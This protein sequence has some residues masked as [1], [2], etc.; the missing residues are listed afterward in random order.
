V[1][2]VDPSGKV[3]QFTD[4]MNKFLDDL[5]GQVD[6]FSTLESRANYFLTSAI[7]VPSNIET[8]L[9]GWTEI[10][11]LGGDFNGTTGV[12]TA[13]FDGSYKVF[14]NVVVFGMAANSRIRVRIH[15]DGSQISQSYFRFSTN[16][17]FSVYIDD[18]LELTQ[19]Q[20]VD[21][22]VI[23]LDGSMTVSAGQ[24]DTS[25]II[26]NIG[27][28][29]GAKGDAGTNGTNGADGQ[30]GT[31]GVDANTRHIEINSPIHDNYNQLGVS[32]STITLGNNY[33]SGLCEVYVNGQLFTDFTETTANTITTGIDVSSEEIVVRYERGIDAN[34][35]HIE[36]NSGAH[37]N[38][39]E[40]SVSGTTITLLNNYVSGLCEVYVNGQVFT[41][42]TEATAT[43]LTTGIDVSSQEIVVKYESIAP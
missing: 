26:R 37:D 34:V 30:D 25:L 19:G 7:A 38:Y 11:D 21:I 43:T 42:F 23:N 3:V 8:I 4:P 39:S 13:P 17:A 28:T 1:G 36:I 14:T 24:A 10:K 40:L 35:R 29:T 18:E 20:T 9:T 32:G 22:R 6:K 16:N 5:T 27:G 15:V 33:V 2:N 41:N 12:Y 31:N